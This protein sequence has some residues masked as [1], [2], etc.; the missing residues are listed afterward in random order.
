MRTYEGIP[1]S[2]GVAVAPAFVLRSPE[3]MPARRDL[4]PSEVP[5]ELERLDAGI[6][7]ARAELAEA[8]R[9]TGLS[10]AAGSI[11]ASHQTFLSDP[12]L[13]GEIRQSIS[14]GRL[15]AEWSVAVVFR[16]WVEKFKSLEDEFFRQRYLDLVDLER[17][18][19]RR[20]SRRDDEARPTPEKPAVLIAQDLTPSEA[21]ALDRSSFCGFATESG[22]ATSHTAI[23][24]KSL[25]I[26]AVCGLGAVE[27]AVASGAT[28]ICD[29]E[30][31]R[32]VVEP[33]APTLRRYREL[34]S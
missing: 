24:A 11:A 14:G 30:A 27:D 16:R 22:G 25:G 7:A 31:G 3:S 6:E 2:P 21:A 1:V 10:G 20:L 8:A 17:R 32:L 5:S 23:I 33:D 13:L 12:T 9:R 4:Q 19:L 28:V 18:V 29:G 26:P 34:Q 15:S